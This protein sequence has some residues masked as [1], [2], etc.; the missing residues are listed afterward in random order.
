MGV[1]TT[2][3]AEPDPLPLGFDVLNRQFDWLKMQ[4]LFERINYEKRAMEAFTLRLEPTTLL[5]STTTLAATG[6][7]SLERTILPLPGVPELEVRQRYEKIDMTTCETC[8]PLVMDPL[9]LTNRLQYTFEDGSY[10]GVEHEFVVNPE[11]FGTTKP[12]SRF[13]LVSGRLW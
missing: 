11:R 8:V 3:A 12:E 4:T 7:P 1:S 2:V 5:W 10:A 9:V 13:Q 6:A